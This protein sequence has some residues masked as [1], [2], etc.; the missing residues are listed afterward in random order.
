MLT[1]WTRRLNK[2]N[3][4]NKFLIQLTGIKLFMIRNLNIRQ[5]LTK[6]VQANDQGYLNRWSKIGRKHKLMRLIWS[7]SVERG[8]ANIYMGSIS[9]L[10]TTG[11]GRLDMA[12]TPNERSSLHKIS[13]ICVLK[14][15]TALELQRSMLVNTG[16]LVSCTDYLNIYLLL[17]VFVNALQF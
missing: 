10:Q 8:T 9:T 4:V 7:Q 15:Y 5:A 1:I 6:E 2:E 11:A 14:Q 13:V 12:P 3:D 16:S 17:H